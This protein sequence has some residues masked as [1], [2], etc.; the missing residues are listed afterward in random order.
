MLHRVFDNQICTITELQQ[1]EPALPN[2]ESMW[3][4]HWYGLAELSLQPVLA[5]GN[6]LWGA[7]C[8]LHDPA[9][10]ASNLQAA[11]QT[12]GQQVPQ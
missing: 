9:L 1:P 2:S 11:T 10:E 12:S 5:R 6:N 8:D 3:V 7:L 4:P